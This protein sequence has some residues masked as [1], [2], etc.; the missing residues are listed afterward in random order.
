MSR[1]RRRERNALESMPTLDMSVA[2]EGSIGCPGRPFVPALDTSI[3]VSARYRDNNSSPI[4]ERQIFPVHTNITRIPTDPPIQFDWHNSPDSPALHSVDC[5]LVIAYPHPAPTAAQ[6]DNTDA[7]YPLPAT[8]P[9]PPQSE[10]KRQAD[11]QWAEQMLHF[12]YANVFTIPHAV[13]T[14]V[15]QQ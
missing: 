11:R 8:T 5:E 4:G 12:Q 3:D 15:K 10:H 6:Q 13:D 9:I 2:L 1:V 14:C 7:P